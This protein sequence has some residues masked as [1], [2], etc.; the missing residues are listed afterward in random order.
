MILIVEDDTPFAKTLLEFTRK[1]NYKGLVAV[2]GDVGIE[3]AK[4]YKPV[5]ILLDIQLPVKDGWQVMEELK[6]SPRT[7]TR[8]L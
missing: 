6:S 3:M 8:P 1:R 4:A 5:A 7:A 2:R